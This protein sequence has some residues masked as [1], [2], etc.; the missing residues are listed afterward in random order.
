MRRRHSALI[1]ACLGAVIAVAYVGYVAYDRAAT[2]AKPNLQSASVGEVVAFVANERG[3]ARLPK[4]E[5]DQFLVAWKTRYSQDE[6]QRALKKYLE[7]APEQ[8]R[9]AVRD[10]LYRIAR[11]QFFEDARDYTKLK[12]ENG[13]VYGFLA[14]KL[15][16]AAAET[17]WV[18][19]NGDPT[20]DLSGVMAAGLPR[21]PEDLTK[22]IV[23]DTTPEERVLGEQYLN[24]LKNVREQEK[25][26]SSP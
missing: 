17:A 12:N 21:N 23:S 19:G 1:G 25:K 24:A 4:Y 20:K 15:A 8:D 10:V 2:P 14:G 13:N 3:L 7:G 16:A 6:N 5:Q 22:L 18:K 11:R 9:A 26:R